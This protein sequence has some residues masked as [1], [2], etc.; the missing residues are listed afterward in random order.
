MKIQLNKEWEIGDPVGKGGF[1]VVKEASSAESVLTVAKF[2]PKAPGVDRELLFVALD[3]VR[4]VVP[5]LDS[6]ENEDSWILVMP[7]A[8]MSLRDYIN[9]TWTALNPEAVVPILIDIV[10]ALT[11]LDGQV[12]HRDLKPENVLR[13]D[14]TWCLADFGISRYAEATTALDTQKFAMSP[15]YAA[16]ERWRNER[17]TSAADI[18]SVGVIGYELLSGTLPFTGPDVT[19]FREQHLHSDPAP[20]TQCSDRLAAIVEECLIKAPE[21][22]PNPGC[23]LARLERAL[24]G[25]SVGL[26][27]LHEANRAETNRLAEAARRASERAT[28]DERRAALYEAAVSSFQTIRETLVATIQAAAPA[29]VRHDDGRT[30]SLTLGKAKL[31]VEEPQR[32][33]GW[34]GSREVAFDV[35]AGAALGVNVS[36]D[37]YG[38]QG[39]SHSLWFC[40]AQHD[41]AYGWFETA[42][43]Y[44][45]LL[46]RQSATNPFGLGP[47][48]QSVKALRPVMDEF[49]VAWPYTQLVLEDLDDFVKR[50]ADWFA[51]GAQGQL[52]MSTSMPERSPGGSWRTQ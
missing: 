19:D 24:S 6:G 16:P 43:M 15:P 20:L 40:D 48:P 13:L 23:L 10:T 52:H 25:E 4:N 34:G 14:G 30:T 3:N 31:W 29:S 35:I 32:F 11:D 42:F 27:R 51:S 28:E 26:E 37:R 18:Y 9:D 44:S 22:R 46:T 21:A 17:A 50:W 1:G 12:V 8:A 45:P 7:R 41:G 33:P 5:I 49:Q 39:R 36:P 2:I 47:G 38:Y